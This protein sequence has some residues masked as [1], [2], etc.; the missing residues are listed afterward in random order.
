MSDVAF[1]EK[2]QWRKTKQ[3]KIQKKKRM[4]KRM[5][6]KENRRTISIVYCRNKRKGQHRPQV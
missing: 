4:L 3:N 6:D 1:S 5:K 2:Q